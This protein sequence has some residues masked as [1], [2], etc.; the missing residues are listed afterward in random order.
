MAT[1]H[2]RRK[3]RRPSEAEA[4]DIEPFTQLERDNGLAPIVRDELQGRPESGCSEHKNPASGDPY[5]L[6]QE[7]PEDLYTIVRYAILCDEAVAKQ[8]PQ[9]AESA[10]CPGKCHAR[11]SWAVSCQPAGSAYAQQLGMKT[12]DDCISRSDH[13]NSG[14]LRTRQDEMF[15]WNDPAKIIRDDA[16]GPR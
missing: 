16:A 14:C 5:H 4:I 11:R 9:P 13:P 15:A 12:C 7:W 1:N 10:G 6:Y 3:T 8:M 2:F